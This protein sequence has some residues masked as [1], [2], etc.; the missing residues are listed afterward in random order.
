MNTNEN[1]CSE[2]GSGV[3]DA[4]RYRRLVGGLL[5]LTYTRP[6]LMHAISVVSWY[7]HHPYDAP[8]GRCQTN[9]ASRGQNNQIW[10]SL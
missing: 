10:A 7:M 6:D 5:Y 8:F 2:D 9:H 3:A 1:L 4:E